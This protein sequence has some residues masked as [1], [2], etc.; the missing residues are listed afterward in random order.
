MTDDG[1]EYS[2]PY[3]EVVPVLVDAGYTGWISTEYEGQRHVQDALPVDELEQVRLHQE[4]LK[5]VLGE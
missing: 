2:I 5:R 4:L 1:E 3:D